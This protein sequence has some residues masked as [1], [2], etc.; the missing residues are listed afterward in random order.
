MD[1]LKSNA[2]PQESK[3]GQDQCFQV[4]KR[5]KQLNLKGSKEK[6][7]KFLTNISKVSI[8]VSDVATGAEMEQE[9]QRSQMAY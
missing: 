6:R 9:I 7:V 4:R 3:T 5:L 8:L 2:R 1:Q